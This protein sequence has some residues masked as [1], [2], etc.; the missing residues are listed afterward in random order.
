M[1][2]EAEPRRQGVVPRA[3]IWIR[4]ALVL[5]FGGSLTLIGLGALWQGARAT[6]G[7]HTGVPGRVEVT[8]CDSSVRREVRRWI[9]SGRFTADDGS[10]RIPQVTIEPIFDE[11]PTTPVRARVQGPGATVAWRPSKVPYTSFGFGVAFLGLAFGASWGLLRDY[12]TGDDGLSKRARRRLE[13]QQRGPAGP[14][15]LGNRARSR[16]HRRRRSAT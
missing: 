16:R 14:P 10:L 9:C 5:V 3:E 1:R 7:E 8:G 13:R 15:Q 2:Q 6:V 11:R 4:L 12:G